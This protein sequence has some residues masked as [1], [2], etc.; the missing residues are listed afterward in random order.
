MRLQLVTDSE[1]KIYGGTLINCDVTDCKNIVYCL[2]ET[3]GMHDGMMM[4]YTKEGDC[5]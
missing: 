3:G 4:P 2:P 5:F 1:S